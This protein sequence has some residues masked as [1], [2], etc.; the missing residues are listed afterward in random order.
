MRGTQEYSF[1]AGG[2]F[3]EA[4][5]AAFCLLVG[6]PAH[7]A[8]TAYRCR[9]NGQIVL[10]DQPCPDSKASAQNAVAVPSS[11]DPSAVGDWQGQMQ[12]AGTEQ[13]EE[14]QAAHSVVSLT[15]EFTADGKVS[16]KSP[17]NGCTWLGVWSQGGKGLERLISLNM[18]MSGCQFA[19]LNRRFT[20]TFLLG[21]PDSS[22]QMQLGAYPIPL[23][24]QKARAY[25]LDG[26]LR[27]H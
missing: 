12:Y 14:I 20:G 21:V 27:R 24:G 8:Q 7:A 17:G 9:S 23:P 1:L 3:V 16:G 19:G 26:T 18:S 13:G 6:K 22:G 2:L 4:L 15:L 10:T 5:L 11:H 25:R